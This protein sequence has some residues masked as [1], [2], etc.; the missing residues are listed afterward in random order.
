M[1]VGFNMRTA[2]DATQTV[3]SATFG[4]VNLT[5]ITNSGTNAGRNALWLGYLLDSE[6]PS[7]AQTLSLTMS[8]GE[9]ILGKKV[10][11]ATYT[12][13]DQANPIKDSSA[14][15]VNSNAPIPFGSEVDYEPDGEL[16]YLM[17][18]NGGL[19]G[20]V[21][22]TGYSLQ[23]TTENSGG[24]TTAVGNKDDMSVGGIAPGTTQVDFTGTNVY[25][26]LVATSLNS[27]A[28]TQG[29]VLF[30]VGDTSLNTSDTAIVGHLQSS[31]YG[32]TVVD[33]DVVNAGHA[34]GENLV[35][36]SE[37]VNSGTVGS[38]FT[39]EA[40]PVLS[41]EPYL[42]DDLGMTGPTDG[43]DYGENV[44][45]DIDIVDPSHYLAA[46]LTGNVG[47]Y[48][49]SNE[50]Q[51]GA[52]NANAI[53]VASLAG[54]PSNAAIFAYED[55]APMPGLSAPARRVFMFVDNDAA[56]QLTTDGWVLFDRAVEWAVNDAPT[57][58]SANDLTT[59][60]EDPVSNPGT[61][62]SAL[63]A[64]HVS[65]PDATPQEG[66]A[67]IGA[68]D[69]NGTWEYTTDGGSNWFAFGAIDATSARLLAA[70][71][72]TYVRFV[73]DANWNGTVTNG[74]TFHAWDQT[75]STAGGTADL[76]VT[77]TVRDD[78]N[79]VSFSNNDGTASWKTGWQ[80]ISEPGDGADS[81]DIQ[82]IGGTG[83]GM[84]TNALWFQA[85]TDGTEV[86]REV[87]L[88]SASSATLSF[89]YKRIDGNSTTSTVAVEIH[90]GTTWNR[91]HTFDL[92]ATDS[93]VQSFSQDVSAYTNLNSKLRFLVVGNEGSNDVRF[94]VDDVQIEYAT[95]G[96][97][98]GATAFSTATA[99]S[100]ITVN[101][102]NDAPTFGALDGSPTF[103]EDAAAVVLD[104]DVDARDD[105]LD[106][107]N[108]GLGNYAGASLTL[109]RNGAAAV[110]DVFAFVDGNGITFSAGNL[111]KNGQVVATF[112]TT[113]TPG[114]M[115][116]SFTDAN[117]EIP[118][119]TDVD[120]VPRQI[121]Y[122]NSSDTPPASVQID[123]TLD[124]GSALLANGST[125][126]NI[127]ASNDTA[128]ANDDFY[129][130]DEDSSI[131]VNSWQFRRELT[132]DNSS[133]A[134]HLIDF[135]VLV[136]LD[137][138]RIDY[139]QTQDNGEDLRFFDGT[140]TRPLAHEIELWDES[141][142]SY[143]WVK[144]PP[145]RRRLGHRLDHDALRQPQRCRRPGSGGCMG[146]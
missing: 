121:T 87:D 94:L 6:I 13:V 21:E 124:D 55:G 106:A 79:S 146:R 96:G 116:I 46:G 35:L 102:V 60:T 1:L 32:V 23:Y 139:G 118:T 40:V 41:L 84:S 20:T 76:T 99:S 3:T 73:P 97:T 62:V 143:V 77:Y 57:L 33:D 65:D 135:P 75:S 49:A 132:F 117:G 127:T 144:V 5:E 56:Q 2:Q 114:E 15:T 69:T 53:T 141:G 52:P 138:T 26:S 101:A 91:I 16:V 38:T 58:T 31:G 86:L 29:S 105:E 59:I 74:L 17:S 103:V 72:S 19:S 81:G 119:S 24:T 137:A 109:V 82:V 27:A 8:T 42:L 80:E 11:V 78:F 68:D 88:G 12:D 43:T 28:Q 113:T 10:L 85:K 126:V 107:L 115:V 133:R 51:W 47:V 48:T 14:N 90:D 67:V 36:V 39:N 61:L 95:G 136:K 71:A 64:G 83:H 50:V 93:S 54:S 63:I 129:S 134:E 22:P 37:T 130:V 112:D 104:A 45:T 108:G 34:S 145:D 18:F 123:W 125:T 25:Q 100:S 131:G 89:Q 66:I 7:G 142:T 140:G 44:D 128:V 4:G 9:T 30:V 122:A 111:I 98:G 120:N 92:S 70:E 110:E